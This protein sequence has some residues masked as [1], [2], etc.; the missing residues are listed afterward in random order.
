MLRAELAA[1]G[2]SAGNDMGW[3]PGIADGMGVGDRR[4]R[5]APPANSA[6]PMQSVTVTMTASSPLSWNARSQRPLAS[7]ACTPTQS[8]NT[9][10]ASS[11]LMVMCTA[12]MIARP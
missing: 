3:M 9:A 8:V 12:R 6:A 11:L 4:R 10:A 7:S 5:I 1:E 2:S